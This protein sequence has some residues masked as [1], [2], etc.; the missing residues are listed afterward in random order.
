MDSK[1]L[2][3]KV[4]ELVDLA[5]EFFQELSFAGAFK[6]VELMQVEREMS[7]PPEVLERAFEALD[8]AER[9]AG[10][11]PRATAQ[12][13]IDEALGVGHDLIRLMNEYLN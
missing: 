7:P 2:N 12:A 11:A 1:E 13:E 10:V 9:T 3:K 4:R 6:R 8:H 5:R